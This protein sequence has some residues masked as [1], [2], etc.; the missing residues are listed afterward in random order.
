MSGISLAGLNDRNWIHEFPSFAENLF[1]YNG[2]DKTGLGSCILT[3]WYLAQCFMNAVIVLET[4]AWS[5][6]IQADKKVH[7]LRQMSL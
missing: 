4:Y 5:V 6:P 3:W 7:F 1:N 2:K